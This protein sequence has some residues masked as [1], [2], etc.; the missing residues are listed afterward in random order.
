VRTGLAGYEMVDEFM[1]DLNVP[2]PENYGGMTKEERILWL[3]R[4]VQRE[5]DHEVVALFEWWRAHKVAL[6]LKSILDE[7]KMSKPVFTFTLGWQQGHQHGQDPAMFVDAGVSYNH[8]MLYEA[9]RDTL[10]SM[11]KQ[12]PGYLSRS[13]GCMRWARWSISTGCKSRSIHPDRKSFMTGK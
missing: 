6:V 12:W 7:A 4:A 9:D 11:Q 1:R 3:A 13:N 2:A 10:K 5:K 8:I